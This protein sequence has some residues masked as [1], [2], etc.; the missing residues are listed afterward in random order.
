[1]HLGS[2]ADSGA[3]EATVI[4]TVITALE[5]HCEAFTL[6][7]E[8][9]IRGGWSSWGTHSGVNERFTRAYSTVTDAC[10]SSRQVLLR[11]TQTL[12]LGFNSASKTQISH[13]LPIIAELA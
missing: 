2:T 10:G 12:L 1:M 7:F 13:C 5:K 6:L 9:F 4:L 3:A 8:S 11:K